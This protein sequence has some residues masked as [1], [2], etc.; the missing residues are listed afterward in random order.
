[1]LKEDCPASAPPP[2]QRPSTSF[3]TQLQ[4][5][6]PLLPNVMDSYENLNS[7]QQFEGAGILDLGIFSA[8][9]AQ[10]FPSPQTFHS[11]TAASRG[12]PSGHHAP[13]FSSQ[14][15]SYA[16]RPHGQQ[17]YSRSLPVQHDAGRPV[18]IILNGGTEATSLSILCN[19]VESLEREV[20]GLKSEIQELKCVVVQFQEE[21]KS[22]LESVKD[23]LNNFI[24]LI[25]IADHQ[26]GETPRE[27]LG[28]A[29]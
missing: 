5:Q 24:S 9:G 13:E 16:S 26:P 2:V 10:T 25:T 29:T 6:T 21:T 8:T 11:Q 17:G 7:I 18:N 1:M 23:G 19:R 27:A 3:S 20:Q 14:T 28:V 15:R 4:P 22:S 12:I